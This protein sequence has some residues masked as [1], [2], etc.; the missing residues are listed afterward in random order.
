M[1]HQEFIAQLDEAKI[2][3]AIARVEQTTSGEIR[4]AI[5]HKHRADAVTAAQKR[6]AKLGMHKTP[7]RNAV[8][9]YFAPKSRTFAVWG[10]TGVHQKCGD[11]FWSGV[12]AKMAP[13]LKAGQF[14]EAVVAAVEEIGVVLARHFPRGPEDKNH[15]P[16]DVV[17]D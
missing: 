14:T 6:F 15:L 4:V 5:S 7:E 17:H 8:L 13:F 9:I 11:D 12:A 16:D 2:L 10:D 3:A 1:Q